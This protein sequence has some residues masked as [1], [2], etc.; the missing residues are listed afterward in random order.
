MQHERV[1]TAATQIA[2]HVCDLRY[3]L[4]NTHRA[5]DRK[6]YGSYLLEA[7][8]ILSL[9]VLG[10]DRQVIFRSIDAYEHLL[11]WA[12]LHDPVD[13]EYPDSYETFKNIIGYGG[14]RGI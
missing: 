14:E 10:K 1:M 7:G 6:T 12:W 8:Y 2:R 11:G 3:C 4:E 13:G 9:V 5:E